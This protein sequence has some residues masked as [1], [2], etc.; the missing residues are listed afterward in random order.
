MNNIKYN[1]TKL[2]KKTNSL[3]DYLKSKSFSFFVHYKL[4]VKFKQPKNTKT[5]SFYSRWQYYDLNY[6]LGIFS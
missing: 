4:M 5:Q 3:S 2:K 6:D 1:S